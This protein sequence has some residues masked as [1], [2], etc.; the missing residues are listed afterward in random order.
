MIKVLGV[1]I[2]FT[3]ITKDTNI[4]DIKESTD[5]NYIHH[6][7]YVVH[8][9]KAPLPIPIDINDKQEII[10]AEDFNFCTLKNDTCISDSLRQNVIF[11]KFIVSLLS[12]IIN[13]N[14]NMLDVGSNIGVWSIVYSTFMKGTI[15]A[16]EPQEEVFNC[17]VN[18][19]KLNQCKNIIPYNLALSDKKTTYLMNAS[20]D[21]LNNFGAFRI[22]SDGALSITADIG[23]SLNLS[24]I[25]FI[26]MDVE[27]HEMEALI[28]LSKTIQESKPVLAVEI[29]STQENANNTFKYIIGLG[30]KYVL[31]LTHCDYVFIYNF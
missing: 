6:S 24:N 16:F 27:G 2:N 17:L 1:N 3:P 14:R 11:E 20:Y 7:L 28:G 21:V 13:P 23:D 18:N 30:Y 5:I 31:K 10:R 9:F 4:N 19:I 25:G 12:K 15:Y 22:S 29:H 8:K 26:K